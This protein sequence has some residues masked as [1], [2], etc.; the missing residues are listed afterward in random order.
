M[1][2]DFHSKRK[3]DGQKK[4]RTGKAKKTN[5]FFECCTG[6]SAEKISQHKTKGQAG[7]MRP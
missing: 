1:H 2:A 6:E 5:L 4:A 7:G 3:E